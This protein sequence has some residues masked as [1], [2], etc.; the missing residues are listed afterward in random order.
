MRFHVAALFTHDGRGRMLRVNEPAGGGPAPRFFLGRTRQGH[1]WRVRDDVVDS[2]LLADLASAVSMES[3]TIDVLAPQ[4]SS[5]PYDAILAR[6]GAVQR[7]SSGPAFACPS[8]LAADSRP[9]LVTD[10]NAEML[11][12]HLSAWLGDIPTAQPMFAVAVNG[13]AV[14]VCASVR[15][16]DA[17]H[18]AGVETT[19][20]HRGRG[21]AGAA[22]TAWAS[23]VRRS[24]AQPLYSTSWENLASRAVARKLGLHLFGANLSIT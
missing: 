6:S 12:R 19:P 20:E 16:T 4:D 8:D 23:A 24:G 3:A 10:A 5:A 22:V 2:E 17:A 13:D 11:R 18:E 21:Y 1:E 7:I 14:A 9:V 15:I